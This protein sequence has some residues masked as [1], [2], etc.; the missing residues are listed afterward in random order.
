MVILNN[1]I[2]IRNIINDILYNLLIMLK[3]YNLFAV[4]F[5][6]YR[7]LFYFQLQKPS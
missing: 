1:Y 7:I 3:Y 4:A 2:E 5:I 6:Y